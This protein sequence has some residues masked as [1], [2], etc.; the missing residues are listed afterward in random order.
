MSKSDQLPGK[1]PTHTLVYYV[2]CLIVTALASRPA[3]HSTVWNVLGVI[4]V[5]M[6]IIA[7]CLWFRDSQRYKARVRAGE[8]VRLPNY[9]D[10]PDRI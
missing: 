1:P 9:P 10:P 4:L 6:V 3:H 5:A 8:P 7:I 2:L